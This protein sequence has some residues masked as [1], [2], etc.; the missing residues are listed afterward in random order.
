MST[1]RDRSGQS[2]LPLTDALGVGP[3]ALAPDI[4]C[5]SHLRW[6]LVYQRPQHL[7]TRA[8]RSS[9]V[10]VI[11][12]PLHDAAHPVME[13]TQLPEGPVRVVPHLPPGTAGDSQAA[14]LR[15]LV[16]ALLV[17]HG[18][19]SFIA[20]YY[21][22]L[23]LRFTAH[24]RP[25]LTVYDCMDDLA[26]FMGADPELPF[27]ERALL[28]RS[29][30]VFTGGYSLYRARRHEHRNIHP[31]PSSI[32]AEHFAAAREGRLPDPA[33]QAGT[34][35]PRLGYC[36]VIDERLDTELLAE[37]AGR[38]PDWQF[39]MVGPVVKIDPSVLPRL[40]NIHW[41]GRKSYADLPAFLAHWDVALMPFAMNSATRFIS[42]TKTLEYLAAGRR[43]VS[44]PV[45][46]VVTPYGKAGLVSI[47]SDAAGFI[48]RCREALAGGTDA[49]WLSSVD[50]CL[51]AT[52]WDATWEQMMEQLGTAL[53]KGQPAAG[54]SDV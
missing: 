32:D 37:V 2:W 43:V 23:A 30:V 15:E 4:V 52:S 45:P 29:D 54:G 44:T 17:R 36:G 35:R 49:A 25:E 53:A 3:G 26:G 46:D 27:M 31:F 21:T 7:L 16:D 14:L 34:G 10:F 20:W 33:D 8:A 40:P 22:P 11:E 39:I 9:R 5:F 24:L 41:L 1:D 19:R 38:Q 42:P 51:K 50:S 12:E 28:S 18:I 13:E 6:D 48:S 47:A